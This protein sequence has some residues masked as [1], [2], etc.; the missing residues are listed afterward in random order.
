[1]ATN[2]HDVH[3]PVQPDSATAPRVALND[4]WE[5]VDQWTAK[6]WERA[7][8]NSIAERVKPLMQR[9]RNLRESCDVRGRALEEAEQRAEA[10]EAALKALRDDCA[11]WAVNIEWAVDHISGRVASVG[12]QRDGADTIVRQCLAEL[13]ARSTATPTTTTE[14]GETT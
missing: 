11:R 13:R 7:G 9:L 14:T 2:A 6:E 3:E 12:D 4:A 5:W 10:A 8:L 1:M